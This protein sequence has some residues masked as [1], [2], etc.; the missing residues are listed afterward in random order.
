MIL[1]N[2][3]LFTGTSNGASGGITSTAY[4]DLPTTGTQIASNV[5]DLGVVLG[6]PTYARGGG[7]RDIGIGD[8]PSM[9]LLAQ[10]VVAMD[11]LTNI[12]VVLSGA[13]DNGSGAAGAYTVMYTSPVTTLA[14]AVAGARLADIDIPR[15]IAGQAMPR[16]LNLSFI[17]TGGTNVAGTVEAGIVIDRN[18]QP[19]G[20]SGVTSGYP[21]GIN[22]AN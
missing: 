3:L 22:I 10:V 8:R 16:F 21:A 5:L 15:P 17:T 18:D 14:N 1:D 19:M 6:L 12:A 20:A 4:T 7:A 9:K 2:L 11:T 13:P